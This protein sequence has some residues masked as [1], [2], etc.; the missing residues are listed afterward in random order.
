MRIVVFV[1]EG[2]NNG[3]NK[4]LLLPFLTTDQAVFS[5]KTLGNAGDLGR[6]SK[7]L[8]TPTLFSSKTSLGVER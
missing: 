8:F 4:P 7:R 6:S 3:L 2:P 1:C 5:W